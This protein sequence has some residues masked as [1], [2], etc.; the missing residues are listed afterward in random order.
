VSSAQIQVTSAKIQVTSA[1]I[2]VSWLD[3]P[4]ELKQMI[5]RLTPKARKE[6]LWPVIVW[7]CSLQPYKAEQLP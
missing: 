1:Q 7:L 3:L 6:S 4:D 5:D 2:Q